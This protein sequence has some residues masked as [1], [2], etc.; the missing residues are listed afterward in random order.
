M[1]NFRFLI[2]ILSVLFIFSCGGDDTDIKISTV[3]FIGGAAGEQKPGATEVPADGISFIQIN[4]KLVSAGGEVWADTPVEFETNFGSF[5][6][7]KDNMQTITA[8]TDGDT[9]TVN[10]YAGKV[11]NDEITVKVTFDDRGA[12]GSKLTK[13][14][15][16]KFGNL[17]EGKKLSACHFEL[18]CLAKNLGA[19]TDHNIATEC[20]IKALNRDLVPVDVPDVK[21]ETEVGRMLTIPGDTPATNRYFY[22]ADPASKP[23]D[24]PPLST[25]TPIEDC[26]QCSRV[27]DEETGDYSKTDERCRCGLSSEIMNPRDSLVTIIAYANGEECFEDTNRN[28]KF[29]PGEKV[30]GTFLGEPFIDANDNAKR[31][32]G[33]LGGTYDEPYVESF[34]DP[35]AYDDEDGMWN[36]DITVWTQYKILLTGSP[37]ES[38]ETTRYA[39]FSNDDGKFMPISWVMGDRDG[40]YCNSEKLYYFYLMD[41]YMNP[42]ATNE[43]ESQMTIRMTGDDIGGNYNKE[44]SELDFNRNKYGFEMDPSGRIIKF[45]IN[46]ED[47]GFRYIAKV[48]NAT[49]KCDKYKG[50]EAYNVRV[51]ITTYP[52]L[53]SSEYPFDGES[54]TKIKKTWEFVGAIKKPGE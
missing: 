22:I 52:A 6:E 20:F 39:T 43:N 36:N 50:T 45:N 31:D 21:F 14:I 3:A 7:V 53:Q 25:T 2:L 42:I 23:I 1:K 34:G 26:N 10:L 49:D 15:K 51:D 54:R 44:N 40:I 17:V 46:D 8:K 4:A 41:E 9:A 24:V 12:D 28:G 29:D 5:S 47:L 18:T 37:D 16:L 11:R 48:I 27:Y 19:Y 38:E 33:L 30:K 35:A 13:A 32:T